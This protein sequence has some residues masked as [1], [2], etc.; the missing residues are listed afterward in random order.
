MMMMMILDFLFNNEGMKK[1]YIP[2]EESREALK[3]TVC[4]PIQEN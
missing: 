3:G 2:Q 1:D 4:N